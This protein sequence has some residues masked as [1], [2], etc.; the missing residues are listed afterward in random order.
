MSAAVLL[1]ENPRPS[2]AQ[3][4]EHMTAQHLPLRNLSAH[5][6]RGRARRAGGL[7]HDHTQQVIL[8]LNVAECSRRQIM[9]GVAGLTFAFAL[10]NTVA[11]AASLAGDR[12]GKAFNPWLRS[13]PTE[14]ITIMS[15]AT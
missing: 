9:M 10:P 5:R 8:H 15:A 7:S 13:R 2:R 11:R 12:I 4:V 1:K 3:I 14:T 6:P